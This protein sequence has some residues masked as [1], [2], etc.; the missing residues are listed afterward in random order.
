MADSD[1]MADGP[2]ICDSCGCSVACI[3]GCQKCLESLCWD[4]LPYENCEVCDSCRCEENLKQ[5]Q[6]ALS[7]KEENVNRY[8]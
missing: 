7:Q 6:E 5:Y 2:Y 4:C 8:S 3:Y 1:P